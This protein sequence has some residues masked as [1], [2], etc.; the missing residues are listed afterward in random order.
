MEKFIVEQEFLQDEEDIE[1][2]K[3]V[4]EEVEQEVNEDLLARKAINIFSDIKTY[5]ERV[6][7]YGEICVNL[8]VNSIIKYLKDARNF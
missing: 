2:T 3:Q 4:I 5:L 7:L 8:N 1:F 6:G